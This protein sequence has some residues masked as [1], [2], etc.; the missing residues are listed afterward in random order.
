MNEI[1][2]YLA[3]EDKK[4]NKLALNY[5]IQRLYLALIYYTISSILFESPVLSFY[6]I[7][8]RKVDKKDRGL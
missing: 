6:T 1:I 7:L 4:E 2:E 5:T 8:S 3:L